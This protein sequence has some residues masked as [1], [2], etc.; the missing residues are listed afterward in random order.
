M[1]QFKWGEHKPANKQSPSPRV[2]LVAMQDIPET[3]EFV[4]NYNDFLWEFLSNS[5]ALEW[6]ESS[7]Y[8]F[9]VYCTVD[10]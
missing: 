3:V 9:D 6:S 1:N 7:A 8:V 2:F 5:Q 4:W 10:Q